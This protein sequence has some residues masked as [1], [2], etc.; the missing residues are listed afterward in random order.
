MILHSDQGSV[1]SSKKYNEL[2]ASVTTISPDAFASSTLAQINYSLVSSSRYV[3]N[4][5]SVR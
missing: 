2:S 1:Y 5:G 4:R 3:P